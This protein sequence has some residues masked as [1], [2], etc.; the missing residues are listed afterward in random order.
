[1]SS[2]NETIKEYLIRK[3]A[4]SLYNVKRM[5]SLLGKLSETE[6]L[7][8]QIV[9]YL[10]SLNHPEYPGYVD[11]SDTPYGIYNFNWLKSINDSFGTLFPKAKSTPK[12]VLPRVIPIQS[13]MLMG[14]TGTIGQTAKSDFDYWLCVSEKDLGYR[15]LQLFKQKTTSLENWIMKQGVEVHFFLVD[16]DHIKQNE[17]GRVDAESVGSALGALL[18]DGL[19][20]TMILIAGKLPL[21]WL[22][23]PHL[24]AAEY[25]RHVG[26]I[27]ENSSYELPFDDFIDLGSV[28]LGEFLQEFFGAALWEIFKGLKYPYK[29]VIKMALLEMYL[30]PDQDNELLREKLKK[31][32]FETPEREDLSDPYMQLFRA[33]LEYYNKKKLM[34]EMSMVKKCILM[35]VELPPDYLEVPHS[36]K[37]ND[38][39]RDLVQF[40]RRWQWDEEELVSVRLLLA[41]D[42]SELM[43][44]RKEVRRHFLSGFGRITDMLKQRPEVQSSIT[45]DDLTVL[46]RKLAVFYGQKKNKIETMTGLYGEG[47]QEDK[48]TI[49]FNLEKRFWY[50]FRGHLTKDDILQGRSQDRLLLKTSC[51]VKL[52]TWCHLNKLYRNAGQVTL[53]SGE[54]NVSLPDIQFFMKHLEKIYQHVDVI[55]MDNEILLSPSYLVKMTCVLNFVSH[56]GANALDRIDVVSQTSWG[57]YYCQ[58]ESLP[59]EPGS[60]HNL[61]ALAGILVDTLHRQHK[62]YRSNVHIYTPRARLSP[63]MWKLLSQSLDDCGL[64]LD[65]DNTI[66]IVDP[67]LL[68]CQAKIPPKI[69]PKTQLK[70]Q[71]QKLVEMLSKMKPPRR[72]KTRLDI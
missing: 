37:L 21:W 60:D 13:L 55:S 43:K 3:E 20:Q 53:H 7:L 72:D 27:K 56:A 42:F 36:L 30:N 44:F 4:F 39:K 45:P 49:Y 24:T 40:L 8:F 63:T 41:R 50:L 59:D 34:A 61:D 26:V 18:K 23:P 38:P 64:A 32:V 35:K 14:S 28:S 9:P 31:A 52:V 11:D 22:L 16:V 15:R 57:E 54:A 70:P 17:F 46:S 1:M 68:R 10:L 65:R 51:L 67:G 25:T 29:S 47:L 2:T 19:Y 48:I 58:Y 6:Q 66:K 71:E 5:F 69:P 62:I 33:T 12:F